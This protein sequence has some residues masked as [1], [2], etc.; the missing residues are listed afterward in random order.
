[1]LFI[2]HID[3]EMNKLVAT[4]LENNVHLWDVRQQHSTKGFAHFPY[5]HDR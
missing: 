4:T 1:M 3:I 2:F 5:K